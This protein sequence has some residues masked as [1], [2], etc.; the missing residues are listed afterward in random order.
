MINKCMTQYCA[1]PECGKEFNN[2]RMSCCCKS[3]SGKY[4]AKVK[5]GTL[6]LPN[7]TKEIEKLY[8]A[9]RR[10]FLKDFI[11]PLRPKKIKVAY[12]KLYVRPPRRSVDE[13]K[14]RHSQYITERRKRR[15]KSMP[16]WADKDKIY[17]FYKE[18]RRLTKETGI[19]HQ[20]DHIIP[21]TNRLV[22]GLH[23]EFNLQILT[24]SENCSKSNKFELDF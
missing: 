5:H 1:L 18:A 2:W 22:C 15:D 19:L 24:K 13:R 20:V 4:A 23:N 9:E 17:E 8:A 21:S 16:A 12:P 10:I 14:S 6:D 11:G 3:H 7:R